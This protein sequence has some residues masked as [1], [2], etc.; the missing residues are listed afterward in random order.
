MWRTVQTKSS[1][2]GAREARRSYTVSSPVSISQS[3][4]FFPVPHPHSQVHPILNIYIS[5]PPSYS[6]RF[7]IS[8]SWNG[9]RAPGVSHP[10]A[11]R[12]LLPCVRG[13]NGP[14]RTSLPAHAGPR[15]PAGH[16]HRRPASGHRELPPPVRRTPPARR[17]CP[18]ATRPRAREA[19]RNREKETGVR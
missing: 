10:R 16:V 12:T 13:S 15:S 11:P 17:L 7:L 4:Y 19:D 14:R 9:N 1:V 3:Q 8:F 5:L 18:P 2:R 6:H